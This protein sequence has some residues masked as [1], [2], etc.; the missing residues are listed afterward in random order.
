MEAWKVIGYENFVNDNGEECVRVF[1]IRRYAAPEGR[2]GAGV[3]SGVL[4]YKKKYVNYVPQINDLVAD[5]RGRFGI[6]QILVL[7]KAQS[8]TN[9]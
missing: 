4:Y 3:E 1:V 6:D 8:T 7:G 9:G 2:T 5:V